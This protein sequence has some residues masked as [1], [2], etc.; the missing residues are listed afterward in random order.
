MPRS[1][2]G[3]EGVC[4]AAAAAVPSHGAERP[5][6]DHAIRRG[7]TIRCSHPARFSL[8]LNEFARKIVH[9]GVA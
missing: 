4:G 9:A 8:D 1:P 3:I 6:R 5:T 2:V 7:V